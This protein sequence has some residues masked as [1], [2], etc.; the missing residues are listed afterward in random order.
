MHTYPHTIIH[1]QMHP[2]DGVTLTPSA[3]IYVGA[4]GDGD[5]EGAHLATVPTGQNFRILDNFLQG[6]SS[7]GAVRIRLLPVTSTFQNVIA[8]NR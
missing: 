3:P 2:H 7:S 5:G 6:G 1:H 8:N 4:W